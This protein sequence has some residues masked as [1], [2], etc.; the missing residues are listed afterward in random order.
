M[1]SEIKQVEEIS[2]TMDGKEGRC[3]FVA[4]DCILT[5]GGGLFD[6]EQEES[7]ALSELFTSLDEA[8]TAS[9]KERM[10]K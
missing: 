7:D 1:K 3:L 10:K 6:L 4:L 2:I 8:F 9:K 5:G